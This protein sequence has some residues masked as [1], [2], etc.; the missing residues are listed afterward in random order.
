MPSG[1]SSRNT[2][3]VRA[4]RRRAA[5]SAKGIERA[6]PKSI[7]APSRRA[8]ER[9]ARDVLEGREPYPRKKSPEGKQLARWASYARWNKADPAFLAAFQQYFYRDEKSKLENDADIEDE[10]DYEEEEE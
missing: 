4:A 8:Q 1:Q 2:S 5:R 6:L 3:D 7:T 9:Y 10:A